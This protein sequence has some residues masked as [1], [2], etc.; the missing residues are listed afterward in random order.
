[1]LSAAKYDHLSAELHKQQLKEFG[2]ITL[3][4]H[5]HHLRNLVF[6]HVN[7]FDIATIGRRRVGR[8]ILRWVDEMFK[9]A[10]I[11]CGSTHSLANVFSYHT[12][13]SLNVWHALID[14]HFNSH[15][16]D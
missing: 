13:D 14:E 3:M 5:G 16:I 8:P 4:R 15:T 1:M 2:R 7:C 11:T 12:P 9:S 10:N 6:D